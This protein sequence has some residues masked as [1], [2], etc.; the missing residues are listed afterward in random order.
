MPKFIVQPL[1][2]N[3]L[4]PAGD[5]PAV[6]TK[7]AVGLVQNGKHTGCEKMELHWRVA[8]QNT[9]RDNLIWAPSMHWK[10]TR[11][12]EATRVGKVGQEVELTPENVV[13]LSCI[14]TLIQEEVDGKNG[15]ITVNRISAYKPGTMD[16]FL[17]DD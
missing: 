9:I 13:K 11:F 1:E 3:T 5:Y 6:I 14:V 10:L 17:S 2:E 8:D 16:D 15:K 12:V 4:L 7:A